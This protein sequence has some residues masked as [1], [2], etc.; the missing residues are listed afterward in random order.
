MAIFG[1]IVGGYWRTYMNYSLNNNYSATTASISF[2]Y[3]IYWVKGVK[4]DD[5]EGRYNTGR[6]RPSKVSCTGQADKNFYPTLFCL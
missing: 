6:D 1:G 2:N 3:G 4:G 5:G